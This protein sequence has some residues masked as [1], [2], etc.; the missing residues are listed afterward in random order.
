MSQLATEPVAAL[1]RMGWNWA[2]YL[3]RTGGRPASYQGAGPANK[4]EFYDAVVLQTVADQGGTA[5]TSN[6]SA[7]FEDSATPEIA[8]TTVA[9]L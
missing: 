7:A 8:I 5:S 9:A 1:S 2:R 6:V 4:Q 3:D